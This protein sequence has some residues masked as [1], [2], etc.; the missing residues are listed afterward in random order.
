MNEKQILKKKDYIKLKSI[1][2]LII[3]ALIIR[4]YS[5]N[6]AN[7]DIYCMIIDILESANIIDENFKVSKYVKPF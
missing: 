6:Y 3:L 7:I 1:S 5:D 4:Y 2:K